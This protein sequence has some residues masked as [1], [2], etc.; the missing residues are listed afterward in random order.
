MRKAALGDAVFAV[1][2]SL[3][4]DKGAIGSSAS[5]GTISFSSLKESSGR[6]R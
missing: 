5:A 4:S 3:L 1:P 6:Q 2:E